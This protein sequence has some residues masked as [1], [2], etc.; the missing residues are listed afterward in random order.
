M[1]SANT[2]ETTKGAAAA[3]RKPL[4]VVATEGRGLCIAYAQS[5]GFVLALNKAHVLLQQEDVSS[6]RRSDAYH[7]TRLGQFGQ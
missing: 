2:K 3:A 1:V 4:F 7:L 5:A 6:P